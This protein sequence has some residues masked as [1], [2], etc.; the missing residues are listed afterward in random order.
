MAVVSQDSLCFCPRHTVYY[1]GNEIRRFGS[2]APLTDGTVI[3]CMK[4]N[5]GCFDVAFVK[6]NTLLTLQFT[7]SP[8]HS[9]KIQYITALKDEMERKSVVFDTVN[10][11]A[12]LGGDDEDA[13]YKP[14]EDTFSSFEF[15]SPEGCGKVSR[16]TTDV[17]FTVNTFKSRQL[18]RTEKTDLSENLAA[19]KLVQHPVY[20]NNH[21]SKRRR[22]D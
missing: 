9:L 6:G 14:D 17:S 15:Q 3:W 2:T 22:S 7:I 8:A 1:D 19:T 13:G 20:V 21:V 4:W 5:Q 11:I 18:T 10:H 12:V 16:S